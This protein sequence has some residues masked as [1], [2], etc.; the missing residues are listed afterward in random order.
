M[1]EGSTTRSPEVP[2]RER[3]AVGQGLDGVGSPS[4]VCDEEWWTAAEVDGVHVVV[5]CMGHRQ[6]VKEIHRVVR[7]VWARLIEKCL[8]R[9]G[10]LTVARGIAGLGGE[11]VDPWCPVQGR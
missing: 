9:E 5:S 4:M 10:G 7:K 1:A 6:D 3:E 11:T 2:T 8:I